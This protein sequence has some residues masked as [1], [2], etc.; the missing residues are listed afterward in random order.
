MNE[1]PLDWVH[2]G[3]KSMVAPLVVMVPV[4]LIVLVVAEVVALVRRV[5]SAADRRL[6]DA[7]AALERFVRRV[8]LTPSSALACA[9]IA[10]SLVFNWWVIARRFPDL[11]NAML[12]SIDVASR[13]MLARLGPANYD[14]QV[15]YRQ[16]LSLGVLVMVFGLF[17]MS[18]LASRRGERVRPLL[19]GG[20]IAATLF[21]IVL[22][23]VPPSRVQN[24][25]ERVT[26][27]ID[28]LR[29]GDERRCARLFCGDRTP[30]SVGRANDPDSRGRRRPRTS[31]RRSLQ[32]I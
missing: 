3:W 15:A 19:R 27:R 12:T 9:L 18:Q 30:R 32:P 7:G 29:D 23:D 28:L 5:S 21:T 22:L 17:K 16:V 20:V 11:V 8:G 26:T 10:F 25:S 24:D 14:E 1:G 31:S 13:E 6:H 4:S 2:W